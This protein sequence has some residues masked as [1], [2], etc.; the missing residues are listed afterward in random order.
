M[1]QKE[2]KMKRRKGARGAR[3]ESIVAFSTVG[4]SL[5]LRLH[6]IVVD[7][8]IVII[9]DQSVLL[10]LRLVRG[11]VLVRLI[12][13]VAVV[14]VNG[15]VLLLTK[16]NAKIESEREIWMNRETDRLRERTELFCC[17]RKRGGRIE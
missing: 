6:L 14:D 17:Q 4:E 16:K 1:G 7:I 2:K 8:I 10:A 9:V 13:V 15:C 5:S 11:I 3:P 12:Q